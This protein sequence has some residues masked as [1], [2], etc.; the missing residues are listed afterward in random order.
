M[1][2]SMI[3]FGGYAFGAMCDDVLLGE[4]LSSDSEL[5][6]LM[7]DDAGLPAEKLPLE[8]LPD[9]DVLDEDAPSR[10]KSASK[11]RLHSFST[12]DVQRHQTFEALRKQF[13]FVSTVEFN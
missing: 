7:L 1:R 2:G 4:G 10:H 11:L 9:S 3:K 8:G 5:L 12:R 13:K 6:E